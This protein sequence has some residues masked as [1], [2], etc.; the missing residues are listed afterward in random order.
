MDKTHFDL[1]LKSASLKNLPFEL[2]QVFMLFVLPVTL[3]YF[4]IIP[5]EFRFFVLAFCALMIYGIIRKERWSMEMLGIREF[6]TEKELKPYI[7]FALIGIFFII[8]TAG[9][10]GMSPKI[11]TDNA[12]HLFLLFIPVSAFQQ[13]AFQGFLM[14][15]LY[16]AYKSPVRVVFITALLFA[17]MHIIY[18]DAHVSL[19]LAFMGGLAFAM[20]YLRYPNLILISIVHAIF[21]FTAVLY[22]FF[23]VPHLLR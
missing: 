22:G 9:L 5:I 15:V 7:V 14:P 8:G 3:L 13:L 12:L 10:T 18:P 6:H 17:F 1:S 23:V 2:Y 4:K 16:R 11:S 20:M 19:P 21:N